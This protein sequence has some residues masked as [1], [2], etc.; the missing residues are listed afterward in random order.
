MN[1]CNH[2]YHL[3]CSYDLLKDNKLKDMSCLC[4]VKIDD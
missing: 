2:Y 1:K 3:L 4:H